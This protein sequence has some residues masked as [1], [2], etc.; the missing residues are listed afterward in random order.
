MPS[1]ARMHLASPAGRR[2]AGQCAGGGGEENV[3][4]SSALG[5]PDPIY[6][7]CRLSFR[8]GANSLAE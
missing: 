8:R 3:D 2:I 6:P 5:M 1:N 7:V 4:F